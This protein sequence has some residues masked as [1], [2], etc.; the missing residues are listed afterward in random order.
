MDIQCL[1]DRRICLH[2]RSKCTDC[3]T[4]HIIYEHVQPRRLMQ[5]QNCAMQSYFERGCNIFRYPYL[6]LATVY[7]AHP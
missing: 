3:K 4:L 1:Y 7:L 2:R 6:M 5:H